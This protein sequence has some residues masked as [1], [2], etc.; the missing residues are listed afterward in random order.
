MANCNDSRKNGFVERKD[1]DGQK[2]AA[3]N[4]IFKDFTLLFKGN[5]QLIYNLAECG[6]YHCLVL[7]DSFLTCAINPCTLFNTYFTLTTS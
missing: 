7:N 6:H 2:V 4:K 3:V 1:F 5:G